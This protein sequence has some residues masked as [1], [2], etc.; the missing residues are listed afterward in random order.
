ML[1]A[2]QITPSTSCTVLPARAR[3]SRAAATPISAIIE[4]SLSGR[5]LKRGRMRCGSSTPDFSIT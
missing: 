5:V 2:A 1:A 4:I 3:A